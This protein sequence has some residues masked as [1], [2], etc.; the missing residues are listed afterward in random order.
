MIVLYM[1]VGIH[2]YITKLLS[3]FLYSMPEDTHA[4]MHTHTHTHTHRSMSTWITHMYDMHVMRNRKLLK[5]FLDH[6]PQ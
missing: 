4:H 5:P 1:Y 3:I 6:E 2:G